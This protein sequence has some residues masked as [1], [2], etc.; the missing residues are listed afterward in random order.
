M[1]KSQATWALSFAFIA[2]LVLGEVPQLSGLPLFAEENAFVLLVVIYLISSYVN[3]GAAKATKFLGA[4]W[5]ISFLIEYIGVTTGYPF[6]HYSYTSAL[7]ALL[8]PVPVFIP[9]LWCALG[10][11]CLEAGG[12]SIVESAALMVLLDVSLDP[13]FATGL[14][15]WQATIG[16]YYFGVPVLNFIGWL[17]ASVII[18]TVFRALTPGRDVRGSIALVYSAGSTPG[19]AFYFLF[20]FVTV[21]FDLSSGV[22]G[23]AAVSTVLYA[24]AALVVA[25]LASDAKEQAYF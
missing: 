1:N 7:G 21:L 18:F 10:Y 23:A 5:V 14:W 13:V 25:R 9:F 12:A 4:T 19:V 16:P 22:P 15:H 20:G 24:A 6:G 8:G 11:F 17:V 2:Y 3:W